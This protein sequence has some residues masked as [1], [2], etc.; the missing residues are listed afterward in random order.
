MKYVVEGYQRN[1]EV[2]GKSCFVVTSEWLF[3]EKCIRL[4]PLTSAMEMFYRYP[5][6]IYS[7]FLSFGLEYPPRRKPNKILHPL[8]LSLST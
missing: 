8:Q 4:F 1:I 2:C 6:Q 5:C 7:S 3:Y